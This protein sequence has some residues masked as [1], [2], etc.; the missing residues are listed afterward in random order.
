MTMNSRESTICLAL[1]LSLLP[2]CMVG[3]TY[4]V[5]STQI[6]AAY[7]EM[8]AADSKK[9]PGWKVAQPSDE[10]LRG[11][12]WV[13]FQDP[14][15][16][17]L[18][19]KVN[20]SNQSIESAAQAFFAARAL[21]KEARAQLFPSVSLSPG[22]TT[23]KAGSAGTITDFILPFDATWTLDLWGSIRNNVKSAVYSA[24]SSAAT[25]ENIR[26][27][28]Q[29]DVAADYFQLRGQDAL[30]KVSGATVNNLKETLVL[31][32]TLY[33]TGIDGQQAIETAESN[34]AAA[35]AQAASLGIQRADFEHA[36]AMLTG[37][38]ASA[39]SIPVKPFK[40][41]I[42][43]I[44]FG[45]PSELLERRP[46]VASA[47][48][49][50]AQANAQIGIAQAAFFPTVTLNGSAGFQAT[51]LSK[52]LSWPTRFFSVGPTAS[53]SL[54]DAGLR[55]ATVTQFKAQYEGAVAS[56]RQ[57]VLTAFQQVEDNL[58]SLRILASEIERQDASVKADERF[59]AQEQDRYALGIDAYLT[60]LAAQSTLLSNQGTEITLQVQQLAA[61]V[62][63]INA[64]GGGWESSQIPSA[65]QLGSEVP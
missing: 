61:V 11:K 55:S 16:N 27:S 26:L 60:V 22:I 46:D 45:V 41:V 7:K 25:L 19:E 58:A 28:M 2:G 56:Y 9:M 10:V 18:E 57:T 53:Q 34:L 32:K 59:L 39:F 23:S 44:Q 62:G 52:W 20:V 65:Q 13:V 49:L 38:P 37:Q 47:E 8:T 64:L 31:T 4:H 40:V 33:G 36:I 15:L 51:Q 1:T 21:V 50:V 17:A 3:P 35:Q 29:S 63:L 43:A 24:Q 12:W 48:R 6:P 54:F 14:E 30:I 42:P 5:P